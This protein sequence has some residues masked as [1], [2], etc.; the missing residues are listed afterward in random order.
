MHLSYRSS[1]KAEISTMSLIQKDTSLPLLV[2]S[3]TSEVTDNN[4]LQDSWVNSF[5]NFVKYV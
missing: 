1:L 2:R 3:T 5:D 4:A